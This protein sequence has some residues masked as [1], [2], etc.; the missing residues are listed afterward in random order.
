MQLS[1]NKSLQ[2]RTYITYSIIA[3]MLSA[4]IWSLFKIYYPYPNLTFDSYYYIEAAISNSDVSTWPVGYSKFIRLIGSF[5]HSGNALVTVQYF[6]LQFSLLFLFLSIRIIFVLKKWIY[7]I[8]FI[9]IF[10]NPLFLFGSNHIMSDTLFTALSML[11]V[12]Q[13]IWLIYNPKPYMILT[14]AILLVMIFTIRYSAI[15]YP[16]I[17]ICIFMLSDQPLKWKILGIF[18]M[19]LFIEGFI[20]Y[21]NHKMELVT[22]SRQFSYTGGW[23]QANN[24]LYMYEHTFKQN[25]GSIPSRFKVIDSITQRYFSE[26][27]AQVDLLEHLDVTQGTWYTSFSPSPLRQYMKVS[28]G[29]AP[30]TSDFKKLAYFG[31]FYKDYGNYL[32]KKYPLEFVKYV[33]APN[34]FTYYFPILEIYDTDNLAFSLMNTDFSLKT[35]QWFNLTTISVPE[36]LIHLRAVILA[37]YGLI[38]TVV[39]ICFLFTFIAFLF[40]GGYKDTIR[41]YAITISMLATICILNFLFIILIAPSVLRFQLTVFI[42]ESINILLILNVL[43]SQE[44][45]KKT[46]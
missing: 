46:S 1:N 18:L 16:V 13:L 3:V 5:T 17:S 41:I 43:I 28:K 21:T 22:G 27:H 33:V 19:I 37:P 35:Q 10:I 39:H 7:V 15:Y 30:A 6:I 34:I 44:N 8:I 45:I 26:P 12:G 40:I 42:L 14:H 9:F 32:I 2:N 36:S 20:Q 38:F 31:P 4:I 25:K 11:W 23:K 29:I 24:A